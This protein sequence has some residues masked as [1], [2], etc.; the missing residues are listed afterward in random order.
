MSFSKPQLTNPSKK[1][2]EWSSD[3][4]CFTYFDKDRG[5]KG[6]KVLLPLPVFFIVLDELSTISGFCE[7]H[8]TNIFANEVRSTAKEPLLVRTF[9]GGERLQGLYN[10][11]KSEA[12]ELGG[13]YTKS[14]YAMLLTGKGQEPELV[15]IKLRGAACSAW[16]EKKI[17]TGKA[18]ICVKEVSNEK[19]GKTEYTVPVF[20]YAPLTQELTDTATAM[21]HA[22]QEYLKEYFT[23]MEE[24][25][26]EAEEATPEPQ[27]SYLSA[28]DEKLKIVTSQAA[29]PPNALLDSGWVKEGR[30]NKEKQTF[31]GSDPALLEEGPRNIDPEDL[32]PDVD[33]LP[34]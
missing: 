17:N 1:F 34:F 25:I 18:V 13:K 29:Y 15:N 33:S 27:P 24:K 10:D 8:G 32:D 3:N 21:D 5:E 11:I 14:V 30:K 2:I 7:K 26:I 16:I 28:I 23:Q 19:K 20:S 6:E 4:A 22:L 12:K 31:T 9:K